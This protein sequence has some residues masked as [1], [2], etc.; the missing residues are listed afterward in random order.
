MKK[1][2]IAAITAVLMI[3][4]MGVSGCMNKEDAMETAILSYLEDKYGERF[5]LDRLAREFN[6]KNGIYYRAVFYSENHPEKGV[7]YCYEE[8]QGTGA[9]TVLN[10][11]TYLVKDNYA[12]IVLQDQYAA[13]IQA[14][15]G[16]GVLVK[17]RLKTPN[18]VIT[19][20]Q[21][22]DGVRACLENLELDP[23]VYIVVL[24]DA[25]MKDSD[26]KEK[27]E[28]FVGGYNVYRQYLYIGYQTQID[29]AEWERRYQEN[30][31]E[32]EKFLVNKS[33]AEYVTFSAFYV[34]EGLVDT[35]VVKE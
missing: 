5:A 31:S 4:S 7:L 8:G 3:I 13:A 32:F 18:H 11:R 10:G 17:C 27:A 28:A 35:F 23:H 16:D 20:E 34:D 33:N 26:L 30:Y 2:L 1:R 21:F 9:E 6:G 22:S 25:S 14:E 19:Q 24:A 12:N 29:F 15:L